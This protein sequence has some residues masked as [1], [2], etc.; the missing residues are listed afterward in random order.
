MNKL[1]AALSISVLLLVGTVSHSK[2]F[3]LNG[4]FSSGLTGWTIINNVTETSGEAI[5]ND[6]NGITALYQGAALAAGN[7]T[8][9]FDF[10]NQMSSS[11]LVHPFTFFDTFFASLYYINDI[12]TFNLT[13]LTFDGEAALFDMDHTGNFNVNGTI[14]ASSKGGS[15]EHFS[16]SFVNNFNYAI[17]TFE[18]FEI[19]FANGDSSLNIDNVEIAANVAPIPEPSTL[20]LTAGGIIGFTYLRRRLKA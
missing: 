20:L 6:S 17:P 9:E 15:W 8:I 4:D 7:Y 11:S 2:A 1:L 10:L 12:N 3:I 13:T 19:N 14:T 16:T 18:L 5:L